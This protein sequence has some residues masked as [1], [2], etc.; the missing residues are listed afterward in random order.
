MHDQKT[1]KK[2]L[3]N[4]L[5]DIE[6]EP[7]FGIR[8]EFCDKSQPIEMFNLNLVSA[9]KVLQEWSEKWIL[10]PDSS[11]KLNDSIWKWNA[12]PRNMEVKK[13]TIPKSDIEVYADILDPNYIPEITREVDIDESN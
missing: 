4:F 7:I 11:C 2:M 13:M 10:V 5:S 8:I 12:R 6:T 9:L 1:K 3:E